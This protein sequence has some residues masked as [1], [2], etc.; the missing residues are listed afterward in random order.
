MQLSIITATCQRP[1]LLAHCLDQFRTQSTGCLKCEQI[2]V[3]DGPDPVARSLAK[4]WGARYFELPAQRGHAGA[5]A[6]DLGIAEARGEYV[7]FWDDDNLYESHAVSSMFAAARGVDIGVVRAEHRLHK[8]TGFVTLPRS[9][10]GTFRPGDID[11]MCVCVTREL[12]YQEK[13]GDEDS[14]PGTDHRWLRKLEA[15]HPRIRYVP[16]VIG[17]H[18]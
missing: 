5:F 8:R 4:R 10:N 15:H 1:A 6:K 13:W 3:S 14:S 17:I 7:G 12:A 16:V 11:T 2:V 9:W 18:L